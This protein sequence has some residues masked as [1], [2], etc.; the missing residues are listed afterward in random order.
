MCMNILNQLERKM[1]R[2]NLQPFYRYIVYTMGAVYLFVMFFPTANLIQLFSF[3]AQLILQG[4]VWR[5]LT[6]LVI[7]PLSSPLYTL[8]FLY[9]YYFLGTSLE[10]KWGVRRFF[11]YYVLGALGAILGGFITGHSTNTYLNMSLFFA[12]ALI[13]PD[14]ELLLFFILPLKIKWIAALNAFFFLFSFISYPLSDKIAILLS[15]A[16]LF[17]FFGGDIYNKLRQ[18][19][20]QYKR[21]K[22]FRSYFN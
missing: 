10:A 2:L 7:P 19:I 16:N 4:Q 15:L 5:L 6:F 8:L 20:Y 14:Y 22:Q 21:R 17:L 13:F 11:L 1:Y 3:D 9:F 18:S 12:F